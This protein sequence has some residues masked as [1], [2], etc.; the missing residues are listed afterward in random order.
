MA[1][2]EKGNKY[3]KGRPKGSKNVISHDLRKILKRYLDDEMEYIFS[4]L[5]E[6]DFEKRVQLFTKIVPYILPKIDPIY[7]TDKEPY[8][9]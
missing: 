6:L 3:G 9:P 2:F 1:Q 4:N 8:I 5:D 7:M